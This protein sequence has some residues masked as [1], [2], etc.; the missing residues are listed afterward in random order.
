MTIL[1][2]ENQLDELVEFFTHDNPQVVEA[3]SQYIASLS[4]GDAKPLLLLP[5]R[6][7]R[8]VNGLKKLVTTD[9]VVAHNAIKALI[10]LSTEEAVM[11]ECADEE[12]LM[13]LGKLA[14]TP[15]SVLADPVCMLLSNLSKNPNVV[16]SLLTLPPHLSI[17]APPSVI[18]Q[19][20]AIPREKL[21]QVKYLRESI[22]RLFGM[23]TLLDQLV[24]VFGRGVPR[25]VDSAEG[26]AEKQKWF[27]EN[28]EF[29]FLGSVFANVSS[30][31]NGRDFFLESVQS[32]YQKMV[33]PEAK[34]QKMDSETEQKSSDALPSVDE[35]NVSAL[36][37]LI[38]FTEHDNLIRRG[39]V[40]STIKNCAFHLTAHDD[41]L[42][43]SHP[44]YLIQS[45]L[46]PLAPPLLADNLLTDDQLDLDTTP[47][48]LLSLPTS[49]FVETDPHLRR[50]LLESILLLS[51]TRVGRDTLRNEKAYYVI[52]EMHKLESDKAVKVVAE[53]IVDMLMRDEST[54]IEETDS[55]VKELMRFVGAGER[56]T[57]LE[58]V[59]EQD[60]DDDMIIEEII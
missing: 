2:I 36:S 39:G 55:E 10:N 57:E 52:R 15:T 58:Q 11:N 27:N 3:A 42:A 44:H 12:F 37:K 25:L 20:D 51:C 18:L 1:E 24:E 29:H 30:A 46:I 13:F 9:P 23:P 5:R 16:S 33:A 54:G 41:F 45:L 32:R 34:K 17:S 4:G 38:C 40:V 8:V 6:M 59:L 48:Y 31:D 53:R 21:P 22:D 49:H 60:D 50:I 26:K 47:D 14:L 43:P 56:D 35:S 28:A 7:S 19:D